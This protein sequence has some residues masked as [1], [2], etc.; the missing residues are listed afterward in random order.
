M[1]FRDIL[2]LKEVNLQCTGT[3]WTFTR[4]VGVVYQTLNGRW[5]LAFNITGTNSGNNTTFAISIAGV[6]TPTNNA[7]AA[8]NQSVSA[9]TT[10][11]VM[12]MYRAFFDG[13]INL[14]YS[15]NINNVEQVISGDVELAEK[16]TW[17]E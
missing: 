11:G 17:M 3:N 8:F 10:T 4:T 13:N 14:L 1:L 6:L 5:R 16:P 12:T 15:G 2:K 7:G 9:C